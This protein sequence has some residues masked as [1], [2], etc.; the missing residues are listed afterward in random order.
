VPMSCSVVKVDTNTVYGSK[1]MVACHHWSGK[2]MMSPGFTICSRETDATRYVSRVIEIECYI[3]KHWWTHCTGTYGNIRTAGQ[4]PQ[5]RRTPSIVDCSDPYRA[6]VCGM[7]DRESSVCDR[8]RLRKSLVRERATGLRT[9]GCQCRTR[10]P[11]IRPYKFDR[12]VTRSLS[13]MF[14]ILWNTVGRGRILYKE[15]NRI[16]RPKNESK[17]TYRPSRFHQT[18]T[19]FR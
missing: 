11:P 7:A 5:R 18:G 19:S 15:W 6:L 8:V 14:S 3:P 1:L 4:M 13:A 17:P 2:Y 9:H 12:A 16:G 10:V